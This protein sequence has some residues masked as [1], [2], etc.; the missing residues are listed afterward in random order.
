MKELIIS[1]VPFVFIALSISVF[2]AERKL[3]KK[4]LAD[5]YMSEGMAIGMC[6]GV[7]LSALFNA[8]IAVGTSLGL[9]VGEIIGA[10]INKST[11]KTEA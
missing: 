9:F 1:I 5:T 10:F 7:S 8:D 2:V 11:D 4:E 6:L 3:R